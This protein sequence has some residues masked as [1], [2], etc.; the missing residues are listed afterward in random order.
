MSPSALFE[1]TAR[2]VEVSAR[3]VIVVSNALT[4]IA[5]SAGTTRPAPDSRRS[6]AAWNMA[7]LDALIT[8][9]G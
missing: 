1:A 5:R 2:R 4:D 9:R 7:A 8:W 6:P 3:P